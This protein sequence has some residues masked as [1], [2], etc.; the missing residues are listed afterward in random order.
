MLLRHCSHKQ[1]ISHCCCFTFKV[2]KAEHDMEIAG[3][4]VNDVFDVLFFFQIKGSVSKILT[5]RCQEIAVKLILFFFLPSQFKR[6]ILAMVSAV[7]QTTQAAVVNVGCHS[8]VPLSC[9][10]ACMCIYSE[11]GCTTLWKSPT[12]VDESVQLKSV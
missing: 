12:C 7:G 4:T 2:F 3:N 8:A 6:K 11:G 1:K 5:T 10:Y 9:Q